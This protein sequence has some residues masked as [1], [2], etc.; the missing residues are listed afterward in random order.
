MIKRLAFILY[1]ESHLSRLF[2]RHTDSSKLFFICNILRRA[3]DKIS[4][5]VFQ[6]PFTERLL[7]KVLS[8]PKGRSGTTVGAQGRGEGK[9]RRHLLDLDDDV[10]N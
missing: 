9:A 10:Y 5:V 2:G 6:M 3:E 4:T 8:H 1:P 7:S